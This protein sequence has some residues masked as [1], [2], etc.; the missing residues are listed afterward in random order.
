MP[1][2]KHSTSYLH[3]AFEFCEEYLSCRY[4]YSTYRQ[5][6]LNQEIFFFIFPSLL[7]LFCTNIDR[8]VDWLIDWL[9]PDWLID[10]S[11]SDWLID[12]LPIDWLIDW[13]IDFWLIDRLIDWLT[14]D[15]LID[16]LN[17][18]RFIL[19]CSWTRP[20]PIWRPTPRWAS[21]TAAASFPRASSSKIF[22]L[23]AW[24]RWARIGSFSA[25]TSPQS[26]GTTFG[27]PVES[28][29]TCMDF[30]TGNTLAPMSIAI[31]FTSRW[32]PSPLLSV[33]GIRSC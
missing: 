29:S 25:C 8:S 13:L 24:W 12:W 31:K 19:Q 28:Q 18:F 21:S 16:L 27:S 2:V 20:S 14:P 15:W 26:R 9:T 3:E 11:T 7:L 4:P 22:P 10:W 30:T 32:R 6:N 33:N 17:C 23:G 1:L 5:G